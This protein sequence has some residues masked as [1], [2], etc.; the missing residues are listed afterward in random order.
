M[1]VVVAGPQMLEQEIKVQAVL[2]VGLLENKILHLMP[3]LIQVVEA[4]L[5]IAQLLLLAQ[6]AQA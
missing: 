2:V 5:K 4:V 6:V 3:L 1:Q